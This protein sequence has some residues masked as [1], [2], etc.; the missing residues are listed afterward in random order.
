MLLCPCLILNSQTSKERN[1]PWS[2]VNELPSMWMP[3]TWLGMQVVVLS[4]LRSVFSFLLSQQKINN[5]CVDFV[6]GLGILGLVFG[7]PLIFVD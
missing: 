7:I 3:S 5:A 1:R 6:E 2:G 4:A